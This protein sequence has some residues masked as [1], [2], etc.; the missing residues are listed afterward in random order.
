MILRML[1]TTFWVAVWAVIAMFAGVKGAGT[2]LGICIV[3]W[4]V[5]AGCAVIRLMI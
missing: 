1:K 3:A 5:L 4:C 2:L